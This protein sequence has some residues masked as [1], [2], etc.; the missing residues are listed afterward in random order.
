MNSELYFYTDLS[1]NKCVIFK[2]FCVL[3]L[4]GLELFRSTC[5]V[6]LASRLSLF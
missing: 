2:C 6:W 1:L 3:N 4:S 5:A